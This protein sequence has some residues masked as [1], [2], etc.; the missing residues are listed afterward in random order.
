VRENVVEDVMTWGIAFW[1][2]GR[3]SP[4]ARIDDNVVYMAGACGAMIEAEAPAEDSAGAARP[5]GEPVSRAGGSF[6]GNAI[7]RAADDER[8]D[9]GEPYCTQGPL[10]LEHVPP[11]FVVRGNLFFDNRQPG[12]GPEVEQLERGAFETAVGPLIERLRAWGA[13]RESRFVEEFGE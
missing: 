11:S 5:L 1:S 6:T 9:S 7:A 10:A 3:G 4:V 8:Y 12:N 2:A 13:T